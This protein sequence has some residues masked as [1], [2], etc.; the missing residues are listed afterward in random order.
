M[1]TPFDPT[2][3][4]VS[5]ITDPVVATPIVVN[6]SMPTPVTPVVSDP[7]PPIPIHTPWDP[8]PD[9]PGTPGPQGPIGPTGP[10]GAGGGTGPTGP[11][12][13]NG[14]AGPT[15]PPGSTGAA[16]SA[17]AA[18]AAGATG[19][20]GATG[21]VGPA[22]PTTP[23]ITG[24]H[25]RTEDVN[26]YGVNIAGMAG[27]GLGY[28]T[29]GCGSLFVNVGCGI[30]YDVLGKIAFNPTA[31][32]GN[33]LKT[34]TTCQ[35]EVKPDCGITVSA[36]GV[37][38]DNQIIGQGLRKNADGCGFDIDPGCHI[39]L[40][41]G[42]KIG[43]Y[44]PSLVGCGLVVQGGECDSLAIDK[45][46]AGAYS[47]SSVTGVSISIS[48]CTVKVTQTTTPFELL[49]NL[50]GVVIGFNAGTPTDTSST[51]ALPTTSI[52]VPTAWTGVCNADGSFTITPST[53]KTYLVVTCP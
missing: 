38:F 4:T 49:H 12:G 47:F 27:A 14:G 8:D 17:G 52:T 21:G 3:C 6:P 25:I 41:G 50:C 19:S 29:A 30:A 23:F 13:S 31:V 1:A 35:I 9:A 48:G 36:A 37:K 44:V 32:A 40:D 2:R 26:T 28:T 45:V 39:T 5:P 24:C 7:F 15:G 51:V 46:V 16:G 22:G 10:P 43:V 34:G 11:P 18:G 53:S 33:G 20:T 42:S